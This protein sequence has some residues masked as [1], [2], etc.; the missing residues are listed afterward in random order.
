MKERIRS[1]ITWTVDLLSPNPNTLELGKVL[2]QC[3]FDVIS[4]IGFT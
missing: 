1:E 2:N 4:Y 3:R